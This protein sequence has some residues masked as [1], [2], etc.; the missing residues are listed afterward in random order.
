MNY[1]AAYKSVPDFGTANK[2][3]RKNSME[4]V[5]I[6][7]LAVISIT[8]GVCLK[9]VIRK[10]RKKELKEQLLEGI[11]QGRFKNYEKG[12][13]CRNLIRGSNKD[14]KKSF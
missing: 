14:R 2:Y 9:K 3:R 8:E 6:V 5:I 7:V 1:K 11:I 4:Y 12:I 10:Y 13:D